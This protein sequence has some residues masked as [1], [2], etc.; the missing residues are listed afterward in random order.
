MKLSPIQNFSFKGY[1]AGKIKA[2]YLQNTNHLSQINI[3]NKLREIGE[4]EDFD[5]FI[6]SK[7]EIKKENINSPDKKRIPWSLWSQDN[8]ILF[9][10]DD[11]QILI[12]PEFY[13]PPEILAAK[14]FC[15]ATN[16]KGYASEIIFEGGNMYF[17]KKD[18][19][20]NYL[21]TSI[22]TLYL[23]GKYQ[24]LKEKTQKKLSYEEILGFFKGG[25]LKDENGK[26]ILTDKEYDKNY[27]PYVQKAID[28]L[29]KDFDIKKENIITF[30]EVDFHVDMAI[31]PLEYPYVL[32]NDD[33]EVDKLI[34]KLEKKFRFDFSAKKDIKALK[35][36]VKK[37]RAQY[38]PTDKISKKLE[39]KGF[40]PIKIA[41]AFGR[42][43][44]NFVNAIVQ[45]TPDGLAYITN[46]TKPSTKVYEAMQD[47]FEQDLKEK[48]PNISNVYFIN[49][50]MRSENRNNIM[51][52]LENGNGGIH[53]LCCEEME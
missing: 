16:L 23:S 48:C 47:I 28:I 39:E 37:H 51:Y 2:L 18:N 13:N 52:Y 11:E 26:T 40:V 17:G 1:G 50:G 5:V 49:G 7:G 24:F 12:T 27:M 20:E 8:K 38:S 41:G 10:K 45:K 30:P 46:S 34:K 43:P 35:D 21:M 3:Y 9:K 14:D 33:K 32:I 15:N 4:R 36:K 31:R 22:T 19:G 6:H 42:S 29:S 44:V 25:K 53:C